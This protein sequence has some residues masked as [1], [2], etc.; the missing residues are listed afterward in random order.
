MIDKFRDAFFLL[1]R[2][3]RLAI[4]VEFLVTFHVIFDENDIDAGCHLLAKR[5]ASVEQLKYSVSVATLEVVADNVFAARVL[6][7]SRMA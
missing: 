3:V 5:Y 7:K 1:R 4:G 2:E 6:G